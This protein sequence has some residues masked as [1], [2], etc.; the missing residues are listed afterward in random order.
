LELCNAGL[1]VTVAQSSSKGGWSHLQHCNG[2]L[3]WEQETA[4]SSP[5]VLVSTVY[6]SPKDCSQ[7]TLL[8]HIPQ[9]LEENE[10]PFL[11]QVDTD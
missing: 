11:S 4:V 6:I 8:A 1:K 9:A 3:Y 10:T 5:A 7:A 2:I